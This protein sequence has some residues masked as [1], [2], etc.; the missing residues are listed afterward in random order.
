MINSETNNDLLSGAFKML[1]EAVKKETENSLPCRVVSVNAERTRVTVE[2]MIKI[3][4]R[5]TSQVDRAEIKG[6][7][8]FTMGGG[9]T[10]ISF[11]IKAGDFGWIDASDRDISLFLQSYGKSEPLT[12]R[13][14]SFSDARF[15]PD[16]MRSFT[17]SGDDSSALVI[18]TKDGAH[19]I[20][21][22]QSGI[23]HTSSAN[24]DVNGAT[25]TPSGDVVTAS[26][27]SLDEFK[28]EYD[29]HGHPYS[30]TDPGGSGT[31]GTPT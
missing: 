27:V 7:P 16:I 3:V 5:D 22:D 21:I 8:V 14:H 24:I 29:A 20:A 18:S 17:I 15:I 11:P 19:K 25:V 6:L 13:K 23:R 31:T 28:A 1:I 10:F 9:D 12:G 2:P 4:G 26:G 30:W